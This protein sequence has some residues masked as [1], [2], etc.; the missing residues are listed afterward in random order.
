MRKAERW[1]G[2]KILDVR[3]QPGSRGGEAISPLL[4]R[5]HADVA[6]L[7]RRFQVDYGLELGVLCRLFLIG[8]GS[9]SVPFGW[10]HGCKKTFF[11]STSA[12]I[13]ARTAASSD[14]PR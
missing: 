3:G 12:Q 14:P 10:R 11:A 8:V 13:P 1:R 7:N 9:L 2:R 6:G 4:L 5:P